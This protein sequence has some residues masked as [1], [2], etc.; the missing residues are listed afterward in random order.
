MN[1]NVIVNRLISALPS[2]HCFNDTGQFSGDDVDN[3]IAMPH[4]VDCLIEALGCE[5]Y[6]SNNSNRCPFILLDI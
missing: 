6:S 2:S 1:D 3:I 5:R 4:S